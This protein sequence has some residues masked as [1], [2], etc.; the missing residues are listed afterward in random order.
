MCAEIPV[1]GMNARREPVVRGD[2]LQQGRELQP[3]GGT[4]AGTHV[5]VVDARGLTDAAEHFTSGRSQMQRINAAVAGVGFP[6]DE[7]ARL[8][9]VDHSHKAAGVHAERERKALLAD[10][11]RPVQE[12]QN[13]GI[14][15]RE[16]LRSQQL[17]ELLCSPGADLGKEKGNLGRFTFGIS[18]RHIMIVS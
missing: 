5:F 11:G 4:Q 14:A 17:C 1:P 13:S 8:Q 18:F 2:A 16:I 6:D 3:L 10:A 9:R 12:P 15:G 7:P